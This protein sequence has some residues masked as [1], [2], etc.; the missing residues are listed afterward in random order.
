MKKILI[1]TTFVLIFITLNG[2]KNEEQ[3]NTITNNGEK[4]SEFTKSNTFNESI[5]KKEPNQPDTIKKDKSVL[6]KI[7]ISTTDDG[8]I[9]IEPKKTKELLENIA[10]TLKKEA[11]RIKENNKNLKSEDLGINKKEDKIIIDTNK[12]KKFLNK[13]SN[14]F[15]K[16]AKELGKIF[17]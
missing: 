14:D 4:K 6:N 3:N 16:T 1:Y 10:T 9:I 17:E 12:T 8:K 7:G 2:C 15:S 5:Q 13:L 11:I